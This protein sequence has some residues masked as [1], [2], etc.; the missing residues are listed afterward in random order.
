[1]THSLQRQLQTAVRFAAALICG[2]SLAAGAGAA[3]KVGEAAPAFSVADAAGR[4]R[5]LGEFAG[6]TVVL[7]WTN[8]DCPYVRKHYESGNMQAVQQRATA[9]GVVWLSVI[10]S[11]PG[12]Q[13]HLSGAAALQHAKAVKAVPSAILIDE[14][15]VM[16]RA[17]NARNT[18]QMVVIDPQQRVV[19]QGAIDNRP[20]A[21]PYSLRGAT[22]HVS[23]ALADLRAGRAVKVAETTPYGC[24]IKYH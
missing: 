17:Y 23:A 5:S 11:A 12:E 24:T 19:Y 9:D 16:G 1:M 8:R 18:P 15:G 4:T 13:G 10:S 2:I 7:E 21:S 6:R 3:P 20:S 22:N 14:S